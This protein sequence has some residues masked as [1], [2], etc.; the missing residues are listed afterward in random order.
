MKHTPTALLLTSLLA[1]NQVQAKTETFTL[2]SSVQYGE[3]GIFFSTDQGKVALNL[4]ALPE[5]VTNSLHKYNLNKGACIQ[6]MSAKGFKA[7]DGNGSG[8]QSISNCSAASPSANPSITTS[9]PKTLF[10][11]YQKTNTIT[12]GDCHMDRCSWSK[13]LDT[14]VIQQTATETLLKVTLLGGS[15]ENSDAAQ[16]GHPKKLVWNKAP[17]SITI[18]CSYQRPSV[19][20]GNQV[21]ELPL[22]SAGMDVPAVLESSALLYFQYCHANT[23]SSIAD[24]VRQYGYRVGTH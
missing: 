14:Q 9:K 12:A 22:N 19:T 8:I 11:I 17:H 13:S 24:A 20:M 3:E 6:V 4:Y 10:N 2:K 16:N 15:S 23:S 1:M 21:D 18:R 5:K 7:E